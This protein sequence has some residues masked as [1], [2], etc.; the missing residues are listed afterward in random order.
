MTLK[1]HTWVPI[2]DELLDFKLISRFKTIPKFRT[3]IVKVVD[4]EQ[5]EVL[6]VATKHSAKRPEVNK[7]R[8][9]SRQFNVSKTISFHITLKGLI[10]CWG[11]SSTCH[12]WKSVSP[13]HLPRIAGSSLWLYSKTYYFTSFST[14]DV[15]ND[16]SLIH[17]FSVVFLYSERIIESF[18]VKFSSYNPTPGE[19]RCSIGL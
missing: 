15:G 2:S 19:T 6:R 14:S 18:G 12:S 1:K 8:S 10:N 5:V 16:W 17:V 4:A 3:S 7:W 11:S 9:D 13:E